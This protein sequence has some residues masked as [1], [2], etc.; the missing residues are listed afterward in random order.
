MVHPAGEWAAVGNAYRGQFN[1]VA[2]NGANYYI[3]L[4]FDGSA[5]V[6]TLGFLELAYM[7]DDVGFARSVFARVP[8]HVGS[9]SGWNRATSTTGNIVRAGV[10]LNH[11]FLNGDPSAVLFV[12]HVYNPNGN[13]TGTM[14]N[15]PLSV[16]YDTV[17]SRWTI[18]N[19]DNADMM[20]GLTFNFRINASARKICVPPGGTGSEFSPG[21]VLDD[22]NANSNPFASLIVTPISGPPALVAVRYD[23]PYWSIVY[24]DGSP[25]TGGT[26]FNVKVIAFSQY[27]DDPTQPDLSGVSNTTSDIDVGED[28]G[29]TNHTIDG[30]RILPFNWAGGD[31][32]QPMI[33]TSNLTPI[34]LPSPAAPDTKTLALWITP[35]CVTPLWPT[36]LCSYPDRKWALY[37]EDGSP[38]PADL[39]LNVWARPQ[40]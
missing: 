5:P 14:W 22:S 4:A 29:G 10:V 24:A 37:Y 6:G 38:I 30:K 17:R 35:K 8:I 21:L 9:A 1:V 40:P 36:R 20:S 27:I 16:E 33:F 34:G 11:P 25:L 28:L 12:S 39:R 3:P 2:P 23:A 13:D 7:L 19:S 15:H 31:A 26:C 18:M 32:T